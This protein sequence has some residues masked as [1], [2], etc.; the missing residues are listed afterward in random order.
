M[1]KFL[2]ILLGILAVILLIVGGFVGWVSFTGIPSYDP[3]KIPEITITS[4][5]TM[6]AHGQKLTVTMCAFCHLGDDGTLSGKKTED[7]AFG[8]IY[9]KNITRHPEKGIG[10]WSDGE[11]V[12]YLRTG[13]RA[14]GHFSPPYMPPHNHI[15][16]E[17]LNAIIA[18]LKSDHPM[19]AASEASHPDQKHSFL[20]KFLGKVAFKPLP[21]PESTILVPDPSDQIAYGRYLTLSRYECYGCH[22]VSFEEVDLIDPEKSGG[23]L[24][25]G[26]PFPDEQG[27]EILSINLTGDPEKGIGNW[28]EDEFIAAVKWGQG[29]DGQPVKQPMMP[30]TLIDS[31]ELR[32]MLAYL[33]T[34]K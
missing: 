12:Y 14:D 4:D 16:D 2:K 8:V 1:K 28:T 26:N 10:S 34:V 24:Q 31:S 11:L 23:F 32:A 5:S 9:S 3:P 25:G 20:A 17:D 29:P 30:F 13:L 33:K 7:G 19:T 22:S 18:F 27:N 15:A 21:F 6:I